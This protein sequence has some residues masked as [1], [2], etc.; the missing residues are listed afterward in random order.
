MNMERVLFL[1]CLRPV[2]RQA[3]LMGDRAISALAGWSFESAFL[4]GEGMDG[5]GIS[6]SHE[7]IALFQQA[8]LGHAKR[9][10]FCL[11]ASK[12]GRTTPH[13]V[14]TW[15]QLSALITDAPVRR[16]TAAGIT[17]PPAKL[18]HA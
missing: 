6:N 2:R 1:D 16:L 13:R 17:L 12:L 5:T 14:A 15:R 3:A 11:D 18:L 10:F 8:L 4:A 7:H 9:I